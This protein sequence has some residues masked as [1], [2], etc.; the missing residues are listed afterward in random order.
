MNMSVSKLS[1]GAKIGGGFALVLILIAA[2]GV[3]TLLGVNHVE[4]LSSQVIKGNRLDA[5]L[6]QQEVDFLKW[7]QKLSMLLNSEGMRNLDIQI[8]PHKCAFGKWYYG[9]GRKEA[10]AAVPQIKSLLAQIEKPHLAL[11]KSA[12]EIVEMYRYVDLNLGN[13]LRDKKAD[14][15]R[16]GNRILLSVLDPKQ[17]KLKKVQLDYRK[18]SLGRWLYSDKVIAL[19]K[20]D[21][22]FA[23]ALDPLYKP[24]RQVHQTARHIQRLLQEGKHQEALDVY[25]HQTLPLIQQV[26]DALD[27]ALTWHEDQVTGMQAAMATYVEDTL[28][29]LDKVQGI[30]REIRTSARKH[31]MTDQVVLDSTTNLKYTVMVVGLAAFLAGIIMAIL[32]TRNIVR[33]LRAAMVEVRSVAKGDFSFTVGR[34][35]LER[36]DEL[37]QMIRDVRDMNRDLA[38]TVRQVIT[39]ADTVSA[40]A[41]QISHGNQDLSDRTQSQAAAIQ[42]TASSMEQLTGGVKQNAENSHQANQLAQKTAEL[43]SQGGAMVERTEQA[44]AAVSESS[45]K[46]GDIISLVNEIAFQTNLLALNAAVE[47]ARAG[48]AGRGFA[49]VAGEVRNLAGRSASAAKEIQKLISESMDKVEHGNQL[50]AESSQLLADIITNVQAVADTV[51][52]ISAA[53]QEQAQGIEEVNRAITQMDE[54]VQQNAAL[55][56]ESASASE[57]MAAAAEELRQLMRRFKL[58]DTETEPPRLAEPESDTPVE[59]EME[60]EH[61]DFFKL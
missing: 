44:M 17:D 59:Q 20:K 51:G 14:H 5:T 29:A 47:A 22:E 12:Q 54:A 2:A 43:A 18:C 15:L 33:P 25:L 10:E 34:D 23:K 1:V 19:K 9:P 39:A 27:H 56:E 49:V 8:D 16:W 7:A 6:A 31:V 36:G 11:H 58:D 45:M 42:E 40:S 52:E 48:E 30:L 35:Y 13:F 50:V 53:S 21:P 26:L 46:I 32:I 61:E 37:G 28:P 55:V 24:H 3:I 57:E 60:Q 38:E 41:N 4:S